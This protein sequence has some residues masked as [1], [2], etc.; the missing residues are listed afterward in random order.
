MTASD[1]IGTMRQ[2]FEDT[3]VWTFVLATSTYFLIARLVIIEQPVSH[4]EAIN[5]YVSSQHAENK[6][7]N[8][9]FSRHSCPRRIYRYS[10][11]MCRT[12]ASH[13]CKRHYCIWNFQACML[14]VKTHKKAFRQVLYQKRFQSQKQFFVSNRKK[15]KT[16]IQAFELN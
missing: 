9:Y 3:F 11:S 15:S 1:F 8:Q 10:E 13:R 16:T 2:N 6:K 5:F 12:D 4:S 14:I 7:R